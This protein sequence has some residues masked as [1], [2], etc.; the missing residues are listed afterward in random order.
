MAPRRAAAARAGLLLLLALL[1][2]APPPARAGSGLDTWGNDTLVGYPPGQA[3]KVVAVQA[4]D[5]GVQARAG[6][7][8][9]AG[10]GGLAGDGSRAKPLFPLRPPSAHT[11]T[12]A[13]DA[14][15]PGLRVL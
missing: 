12:N 5:D 9:G 13:T 2:V 4:N 10:A 6:G 15:G 7:G 3:R 8:G 1:A 11:H 14:R